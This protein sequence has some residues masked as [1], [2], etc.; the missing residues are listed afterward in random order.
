MQLG[1]NEA[2]TNAYVE[3]AMGAGKSEAEIT[4]ALG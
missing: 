4:A 3:I 2:I 1:T